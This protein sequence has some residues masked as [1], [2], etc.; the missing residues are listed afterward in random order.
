[1]A[2]GA[3]KQLLPNCGVM[4]LTG[5]ISAIKLKLKNCY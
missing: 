1:V 2:L 5:K 3:I 4:P